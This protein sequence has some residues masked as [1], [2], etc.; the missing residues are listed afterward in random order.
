MKSCIDLLCSLELQSKLTYKYSFSKAPIE[1]LKNFVKLFEVV[2]KTPL[3]DMTHR[4]VANFLAAHL[5]NSPKR[6]LISLNRKRAGKWRKLKKSRGLSN[7]I[8]SEQVDSSLL[9]TDENS[10]EF[11]EIK[12]YLQQADII[13]YNPLR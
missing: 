10:Q 4:K 9:A 12:T 8:T 2:G 13:M 1:N 5:R 6:F 7:D 11:G 3:E